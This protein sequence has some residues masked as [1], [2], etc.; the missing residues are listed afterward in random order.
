MFS[1]ENLS[2]TAVLVDETPT[3]MIIEVFI[4]PAEVA[5]W[6]AIVEVR[7]FWQKMRHQGP[8]ATNEGRLERL[9]ELNTYT[10]KAQAAA[11]VIGRDFTAA[12]FM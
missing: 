12:D 2:S 8:A 9:A 7:R 1:V 4:D 11:E 5:Y 10:S 3:S 6:D